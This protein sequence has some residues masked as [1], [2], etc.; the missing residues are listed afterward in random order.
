[1]EKLIAGA[2]ADALRRGRDR[3]N[4]KFAYA[5]RSRPSLDAEAFKEHLRLTVEPIT[6]AVYAAAPGRVDAVVEVL[7]DLSLEL[8]GKEFFGAK[9]RYPAILEGWEVLFT[10]LP[11]LLAA[12]PR[13]FAG[14]VTNA[15]YNLSVAPDARPSF[16]VREMARIGQSCRDVPAFLEVGK[17]VAWRSGL[18]HYREGALAA[19]R[20]LDPA[21]ARAALR[22]TDDWPLDDVLE[23]LQRDPWFNPALAGRSQSGAKQ[24]RIVRWAGGF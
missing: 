14:A 12:A 4:T 8:I 3:Y 21:L 10:S 1:M 20:N 7:Y 13:P 23:R 17:V 6:E 18:P 22:M 5:R 19:C 2:L 24:L 11:H 16:W 9:T 15:L